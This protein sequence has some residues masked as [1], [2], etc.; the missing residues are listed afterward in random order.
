M[1]HISEYEVETKFI[2]RLISIG[3]EYVELKNYD[4]VLRNLRQQ[5]ERFNTEAIKENRKTPWN[6]IEY[7]ATDAKTYY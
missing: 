3:Y 4:D 2:E 1:S 6:S 5:L 7:K